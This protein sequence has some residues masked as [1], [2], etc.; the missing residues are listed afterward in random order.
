MAAL[1]V[2]VLD[3]VSLSHGLKATRARK[4]ARIWQESFS[5]EVMLQL[6][7]RSTDRDVWL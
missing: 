4:Y 3:S 7:H 5:D 2:D 1:H 6:G